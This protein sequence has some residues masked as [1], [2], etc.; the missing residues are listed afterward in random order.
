L[1]DMARAIQEFGEKFRNAGSGSSIFPAAAEA[2]FL[3][4]AGD[5]DIIQV[6]A[7]ACID[8]RDPI[9]YALL[10]STDPDQLEANILTVGDIYQMELPQTRLAVLSNCST[11]G[12]EIQR[13][14]GIASIARAFA[15]AGCPGL[16]TAI[17]D[18]PEEPTAEILSY[19]YERV[20]EGMPLDIALQKARLAYLKNHP[21]KHPA[22]WANLIVFG[23]V[24]PLEAPALQ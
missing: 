2:D 24:R 1:E 12:G 21:D 15:Y 14:E 13:G 4:R 17:N 16:I 22:T 18:I 6:A 11:G 7:H 8:N 20:L 3:D 23:D 9:E 10:F 19:F 5:F